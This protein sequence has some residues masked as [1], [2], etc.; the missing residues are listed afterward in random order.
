MRKKIIHECARC[1]KQ[2]EYREKR[3]LYL[4][5]VREYR[6]FAD[7]KGVRP[8][9]A[10]KLNLCQDCAFRAVNILKREGFLDYE[11]ADREQL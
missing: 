3:M 9:A 7:V 8:M 11:K 5:D 10:L 4:Y 1:G 6:R 2:M